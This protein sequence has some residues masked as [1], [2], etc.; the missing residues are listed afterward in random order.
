MNLI[1]RRN[2]IAQVFL[3]IITFGLYVIYWFYQTTCELKAVAKDTEASPTLWTILMF[4]PFGVFYS[5]YKQAE[6]YEKVGTEKL[7]K[8]I[9]FILWFFFSPAV[10]FLVQKDL[11]N[12]S[13]KGL[14]SRN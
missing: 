3:V 13:E 6:L 11:N 10:W 2:M 14:P 9:I 12:W 7:N 4:V 5:Y 1:K 8:W